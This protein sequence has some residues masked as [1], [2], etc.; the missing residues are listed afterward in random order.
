MVT[1][2][3]RGEESEADV[4]KVNVNSYPPRGGPSIVARALWDS[5]NSN[6]KQVLTD[7]QRAQIAVISSL[8]RFQQ[9]EEIYREG[10]RADAVF[11]IIAGVVKSYR[12][13]P[14]ARRH[15]IGFLFPDDLFGLAED[16]RYVNSTKAATTVSVYHIPVPA[17][18]A[19]LRKDPGLEFHVIC[20]LCHEL[21]EAQRH[22]FLLSR[23]HALAKVGLFLQMLEDF[24]AAR[25][26]GTGEIYLPMSR[27]DIADY[28]GVSLEAVSRSFRALS[29]RGVIALRN[30]RHI[31]IIDRDRLND[32]ASES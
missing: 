16:G 28:V 25:G 12:S 17:L 8:V 23:H 22:A 5:A 9:G 11:N 31:K 7:E 19:R 3:R 13:L 2:T 1:K 30:R 4:N 27:S 15:I 18:E 14:D 21:R 10:D 26:E 6:P 29:T 24:Q 32:I 20:K